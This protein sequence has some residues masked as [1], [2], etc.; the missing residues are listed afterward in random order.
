M[1]LSPLPIDLPY[2]K[3]SA[4]NDL[5]LPLPPADRKTAGQALQ[6]SLVDL[7]DLSS[8]AK[9][10]HW[11]LRGPGFRSLHL[12]LDEIVETTRAF[13]DDVAERASALGVSP[14]GRP[15][16]VAAR[17]PRPFPPGPITVA[18]ALEVFATLYGALIPRMRGRISDTGTADPVTQDLLISVTAALEKQ[19]W[20]LRAEDPAY[21]G[22]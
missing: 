15:V 14:D 9:Q 17:G 7:L 2:A 20:M 10:A 12:H 8:N 18:E 5:P 11:N 16:T 21:D 6:D 4:M 13:A 22:A 3:D 1:S 19:Y